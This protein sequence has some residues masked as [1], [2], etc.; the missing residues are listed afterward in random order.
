MHLPEERA[1]Y[2]DWYGHMSALD[3]LFGLH[4]LKEREV[5]RQGDTIVCVSAG[6]GY[7]WSAIVIEWGASA[8]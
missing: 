7:T 8:I 6:T 3:P 1:V 5:L 4:L 2:L